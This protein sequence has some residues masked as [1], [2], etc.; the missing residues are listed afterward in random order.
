MMAT[1]AQTIWPKTPYTEWTMTE[2]VH[3]LY[4]SPWMKTNAKFGAPTRY[5]SDSPDRPPG[6]NYFVD[7]RLYSALPAFL[8]LTRDAPN[9]KLG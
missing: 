3:I 1:T 9:T 6:T 7:L 4:D 5:S 8:W 2:V